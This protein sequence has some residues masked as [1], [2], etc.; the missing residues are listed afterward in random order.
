MIPEIYFNAFYEFLYKEHEADIYN[1]DLIQKTDS[2]YIINWKENDST[3]VFDGSKPM[4]GYLCGIQVTTTTT[5][6]EEGQII[7]QHVFK[8]IKPN[9]NFIFFT[10]NSDF[11]N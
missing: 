8:S 6:L 11:V 10:D 9:P 7:F 1:K 5:T 3:F 2:L 4:N